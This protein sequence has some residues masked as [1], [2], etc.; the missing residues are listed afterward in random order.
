MKDKIKEYS[1]LDVLN[2][3]VRCCGEIKKSL[4]M[5]KVEKKSFVTSNVRMK[6]DE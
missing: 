2:C 6:D 4:D 3:L 1:E 5:A